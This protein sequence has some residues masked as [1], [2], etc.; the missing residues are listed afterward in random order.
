MKCFAIRSVL[1]LMAAVAFAF[2]AHADDISLTLTPTNGVV[3]GACRAGGGLGLYP[4]R[5]Q[6]VRMG[7]SG[8]LLFRRHA[9]LWKLLGLYRKPVLYSRARGGYDDCFTLEPDEY[10][11]NG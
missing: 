10:D 7:G 11:G 6:W 8:R 1:M 4:H 3:A 5:Q 2:G 9:T